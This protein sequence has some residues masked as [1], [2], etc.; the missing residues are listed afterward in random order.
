M[1]SAARPTVSR[2]AD[3][4]ASAQQGHHQMAGRDGSGRPRRSARPPRPPPGGPPDSWA[5]RTG[6]D[7]RPTAPPRR[8]A[9]RRG[10]ARGAVPTAAPANRTRPRRKR[11][12]TSMATASPAATRHG[13][14]EVDGPEDVPQPTGQ[15]DDQVVR[16]LL[17]RRHVHGQHGR[18]GDQQGSSPMRHS[19]LGWRRTASSG[20]MPRI[21]RVTGC[22]QDDSAGG[23]VVLA[24]TA[25]LPRRRASGR[26]SKRQCSPP[27]PLGAIWQAAPMDGS[28]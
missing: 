21:R 18:D 28:T 6:R 27:P 25:M 2:M 23:G 19:S 16:D 10:R 5:R 11:R 4:T 22:A 8:R 26:G 20:T 7:R 17:Q 3:T 13:P 14:G 15:A 12:A 24:T 1:T 9:W